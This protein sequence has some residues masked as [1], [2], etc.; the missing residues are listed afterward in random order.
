MK[1]G[2]RVVGR[3]LR[4]GRAAQRHVA[5]ANV[6]PR[7]AGATRRIERCG[8]DVPSGGRRDHGQPVHMR[9]G[10]ASSAPVAHRIGAMKTRAD[11]S[12]R[13]MSESE[14]Y[15][16]DVTPTLL[17]SI[18]AARRPLPTRPLESR[19]RA[20]SASGSAFPQGRP[21]LAKEP[22]Q[23]VQVCRVVEVAD[24]HEAAALL[25][26]ALALEREEHPVRVDVPDDRESRFVHA[27][28]RR[29]CREDGRLVDLRDCEHV[30]GLEVVLDLLVLGFGDLLAADA[31]ELSASA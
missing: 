25:E 14:T 11:C 3:R 9:Q 16:E 4:D 2:R 22:E 24:K 20:A 8:S 21:H 31:S 23:A 15:P 1:D 19:R 18:R 5:P 13:P 12:S 6:A 27:L 29:Q 17:L 7:V 28:L 26:A 10:P 30:I